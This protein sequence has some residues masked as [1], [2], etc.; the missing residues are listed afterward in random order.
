MMSERSRRELREKVAALVGA[1][2]GGSFEAA[3][4]HYGRHPTGVPA[5]TG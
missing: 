1:R 4:R 5:G 3:L 2:F